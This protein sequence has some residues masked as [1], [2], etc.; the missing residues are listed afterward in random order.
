VVAAMD[1][2]FWAVALG[3]FLRFAMSQF[4]GPA[5][6]PR[7]PSGTTRMSALSAFAA[8]TVCS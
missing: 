6:M 8:R 3:A 1:G 5:R 7:Y 2:V 4:A